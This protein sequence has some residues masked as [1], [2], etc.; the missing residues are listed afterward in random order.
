MKIKMRMR[1][2]A[3]NRNIVIVCFKEQYHHWHR[4]NVSLE[5][6]MQGETHVCDGSH[7]F[8]DMK[9]YWI[10]MTKKCWANIITIDRPSS[11]DARP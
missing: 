10:R 2:H 4:L 6:A 3:S 8:V 7:D 1:F 11:K 5:E 9:H